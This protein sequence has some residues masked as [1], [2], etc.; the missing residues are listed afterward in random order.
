M[1]RHIPLEHGL[2]IPDLP[3]FGDSPSGPATPLQAA[4]MMVLELLE[5][6]LPEGG[7]TV[8]T[9]SVGGIVGLEAL[10]ALPQVEVTR[11]VL[12]AGTL[13]S[14]SR[15]AA[16][17]SSALSNPTLTAM[18]GIHVGAGVIP[19]TDHIGEVITR[20]QL[21]ISLL[22]WPFLADPQKIPEADLMAALP[23]RG[24]RQAARAIWASR[25]IDLAALMVNTATR[26]RLV[27]GIKDRLISEADV[28]E[29]CRILEPEALI[30][31]DSCGHWPHVER[32]AETAAAALKP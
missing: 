6:Y 4:T 18:V 1:V 21:L 32:P 17:V 3:G 27:H 9:H 28:R 22:L 30:K 5:N 16:S 8:V 12:V 15:V 11:L 26:V 25:R 10:Q 19:I 31:L 20:H 7:I 13:L 24:G 14:A 29:A 2:L 23:H